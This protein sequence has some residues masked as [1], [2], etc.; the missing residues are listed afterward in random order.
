M[1]LCSMW[2]KAV[3]GMKLSVDL[4]VSPPFCSLILLLYITQCACERTY[5][6]VPQGVQNGCAQTTLP[7]A[8]VARKGKN[9]QRS[10][11]EC[12]STGRGPRAPEGSRMGGSEV[13]W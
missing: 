8:G 10:W 5:Y 9:S 2:N 12:Q 6:G 13:N 4:A 3:G 1:I 7:K 11:K